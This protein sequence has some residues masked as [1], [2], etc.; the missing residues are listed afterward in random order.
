MITQE[1]INAATQLA[2]S[3]LIAV[4]VY[5]FAGRRRG[6]FFVFTGLIVP[7]RRAI[8]IASL[9]AL[10]LVPLTIALFHFT[11]LGEAGAA[12]NTVAGKI[13]ALG[14]SGETV[15]VIFITAFFKTALAEEIFF[16]GL[17][18]KG[19]IRWLGLG[20]GNILQAIIFG[21]VHLLI[22]IVPGGPEFKPLTAAALFGLPALAGWIIAQIN[23]TAGKGSIFPGWIIHALGN[24]VAYP[25]LAF[26]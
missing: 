5:L 25:V 4:I 26:L 1:A 11:D 14:W 24:A 19:L 20:V 8:A 7:P 15:G 13:R 2:A 18:A 17:I 16:R 21:S 12:D 3:L 22:F 9:T 6:N 10:V 23:E